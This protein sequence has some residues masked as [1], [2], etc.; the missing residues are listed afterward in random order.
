MPKFND[1]TGQQFGRLTVLKKV[2][3]SN[4]LSK[5]SIWECLCLCGKITK[6]VSTSL[7]RKLT[8]SCGCY[9]IETAGRNQKK[10]KNG[11]SSFNLLLHSYKKGAKTRN[12]CWELSLEE[13]KLLTKGICYYCGIEP[14]QYIKRLDLNGD[15]LH[16]GIDRKVNSEGYYKS[17]CV[18]CCGTCNWLKSN[19]TEQDFI[20]Q[21]TNIYKH[22]IENKDNK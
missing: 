2:G 3:I 12:L 5:H 22:F 1:L 18:S 9:F 17:N 16:N 8:R 7:T 21:I 14:K 11:Q 19:L 4:G 15:Y 13:F 6:I 10:L 20:N